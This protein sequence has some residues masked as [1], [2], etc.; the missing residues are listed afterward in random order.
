[1]HAQILSFK[2]FLT[3]RGLLLRLVFYCDYTLSFLCSFA[4]TRQGLQ[5]QVTM[6]Q[7]TRLVHFKLPALVLLRYI[8]RTFKFSNQNDKMLSARNFETSFHNHFICIAIQTS[9]VPQHLRHTCDHNI[10]NAQTWM[11][12]IAQ[13][14]ANTSEFRIRSSSHIVP[15]TEY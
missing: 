12:E 5:Q 7:H 14:G 9:R 4:T 15:L 11:N 3:N 2:H 1:M 8:I 6:T 13:H 10:W